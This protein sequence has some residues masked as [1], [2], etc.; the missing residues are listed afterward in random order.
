MQARSTD[1]SV[2]EIVREATGASEEDVTHTLEECN[3]DVNQAT[4]MLIDGERPQ[5]D[6]FG[7]ACM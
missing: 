2:I 3:Y 6:S 7:H 1:K 4:N 5:S